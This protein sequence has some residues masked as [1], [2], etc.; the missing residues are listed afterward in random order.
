[1]FRDPDTRFHTPEKVPADWA[2]TNFFYCYVPEHRVIAW[3]YLM[4]RPG[5]GAL[6]ADVE[7]NGDL[8][9][10]PWGA[11]YSDNQNHLAIPA[12]LESFDLPNGL[13]LRAHSIRDYRIDYVGIDRTELHLDVAG[14]ME[15]FDIHDPAMDPLA[16]ADPSRRSDGWDFAKAYSNH[17]DMTCRV[18]GKLLV[19]GRAYDVDCVSTMDHSWGPRPEREQGPMAWLNAHFGT[20]Y[21]LQSIWRSRR[22]RRVW[23]R[24]PPATRRHWRSLAPAGFWRRTS[25]ASTSGTRPGTR[26]ARLPERRRGCSGAACPGCRQSCRCDR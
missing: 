13:S 1:M 9:L 6:K 10:D 7:I 21:A 18:T 17:F 15:P 8:S 22:S 2:E 16:V 3:V 26:C 12:R 4:A 23:S 5:V 24:C 14:L 20:D 25:L 11:W 19:R